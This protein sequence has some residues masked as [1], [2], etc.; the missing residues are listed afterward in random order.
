MATLPS[1]SSAIEEVGGGVSEGSD[2]ICVMSCMQKGTTNP[3][4]VTKIQDMLDEYGRG[5]GLEF[6]GHYVEQTKLP[7]LFVRLPTVT[8][9]ALGP[10]DTTGTT[11]TSVR[12][13]TG[14]PLDDEEIVSKVVTGGTIGVAGIEI[15]VSRDGG[16]TYGPV[17]RLGTATSYLIPNTGITENYAAG[18]LVANDTAK[19]RT[20]SARYDN[21]GL[22]AAFTAVA[23]QGRKPRLFLICGDIADITTAQ[24]ILDEIAAYETTHKRN[25][26]VLFCA[27]QKTFPAVMQGKPT[28]IDF[29]TTLD[30]I[31]RNTGS[32]I[33]DG[34]KVGMTI[35]ITGTTLN[36]S[37]AGVITVVTATVLTFASGI[38]TELNVL[39]SAITITGLETS[40]AWRTAV[41]A[42]VGL[43]PQTELL[44][45]RAAIRAGRARRKSPIDGTRK[46]RPFHWFEAIRTMAHDLHVSAA[47]VANGP[48]AGVTIHDSTGLLEDH[49]ERVNGGLLPLRVGSA[50]TLHD[51]AG[52]YL[53]LP[54]SLGVD[55]GPLSRLPVGFVADLACD[56]GTRALTDKLNGSLELNVDGT[57]TEFERQ[58]IQQYVLDEL[59]SALLTRGPE[60]PRASSVDFTL[61]GNVPIAPGAIIPAE[62]GL[63]P[64]GYLERVALTVRVGFGG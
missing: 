34:F 60:G 5:E 51:R 64:L 17:I 6:A 38:T 52:V 29:D 41:N 21:P 62:V 12:T 59:R 26:R 24:D 14:T 49:D 55:N 16:T 11:G 63:V 56:V 54:V 47:Q 23:A 57:P 4:L 22:T 53:S 31:T 19:L 1:V 42:I 32:W 3:L 33:T 28:D 15:K 7:V 46:R 37:F 2:L 30:T 9:A 27:R 58:R 45:D 25:A 61:A 8:A 13:F 40:T 20:T 18:T 35:A 36:D 43:T 10:A 50:T 48:L 44:E 39:G